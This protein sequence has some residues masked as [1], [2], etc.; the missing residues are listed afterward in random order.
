MHFTH[1][2][3][4]LIVLA[5][6]IVSGAF[7]L[8]EYRNK[9][10]EKVVYSAPT[11]ATTTEALSSDLQNIDSDS[12]GLKDWEEVLLGTNPDKA[13]TDGDGTSDG[14]EATT[15]RNP[16]VKGPNDKAAA[17]TDAT[18]STQNLTATDKLAR[19][20]FAKYMELNQVGLAND[21]SSQLNLISEVIQKG[22]VLEKPKVYGQKDILIKVDSSPAAIRAYANE[23]GAIFVTFSNPQFRNETVIT[24]E[25]IEQED[26]EILK[27]LDPIILSYKNILNGL[28]KVSAPLSISS[29]HL[30][31]VNSISALYFSAQALRKTDSDTI[32][33]LSGTSVW[34][35]GATALNKSFNNLKAVFDAN[36]IVFGEGEAGKFF[37]PQ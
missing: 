4:L 9:Q 34:L 28:M 27:E 3:I 36:N 35:S 7:A 2:N 16:L 25:S 37:I 14:K 31:L 6:L 11:L 18:A 19:D 1:K 21:K 32:A 8:A 24:K 30:A 26:P 15:G 13:D 20:F 12:D 33:S 10:V 17:T 23:V 22:I 5:A 29:T